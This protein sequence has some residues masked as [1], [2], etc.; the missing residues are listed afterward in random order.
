MS[1]PWLRTLSDRLFVPVVGV[2][3]FLL[4]AAAFFHFNGYA[5]LEIFAQIAQGAFGGAL[6]TNTTLTKTIP[7]LFCALATALPARMGL[8]SVGAEGQLYFG[9][10]TGTAVVLALTKA[11]AWVLLP[12]ALALTV[13]GG[14]L[15]GAIPGVL[16][17]ALGVN[18]TIVT[19]LM[20]YVGI[21]LVEY[22]VYG[23]WKDPG[24]LGWPAT[25]AF[26][27]AAKFPPIT[28]GEISSNWALVLAVLV[29]LALHVLAE[30]SRLGTSLALLRSNPRVAR[31]SG[32]SYARHAVAVMALAGSLAGLAGWVQTANV[33]NHLQPDISSG[34]GYV[35]FLVAWLAGQ[36]FLRII[37][38]SLV[39]GGL[40]SAGD[41]LQLFAQMPFAN[42]VVMQ[43]LVFISVLGVAAWRAKR[44]AAA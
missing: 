8:I 27:D 37:P 26:P 17:A 18:E 24:N 20:N 19:I 29:A 31:M 36:N 6:S 44:K 16:R 22:A 38:L 40:L 28:L 11:S 32:L 43:A 15:W 1:A 9:A 30:K 7:I 34:Y 39:M 5:P 42:T 35:G 21:Q 25:I 14:A 2:A 41:A 33:Q 12:A 4:L 10:L 13:A 3:V 23:P